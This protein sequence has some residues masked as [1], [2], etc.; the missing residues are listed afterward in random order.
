[1]EHGELLP[2]NFGRACPIPSDRT[3]DHPHST[4]RVREKLLDEGIGDTKV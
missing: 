3:H 1:V 4:N 2:R